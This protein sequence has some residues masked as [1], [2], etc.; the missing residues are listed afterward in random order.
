MTKE[1]P[2]KLL[3]AFYWPSQVA[4]P[5]LKGFPCKGKE[6]SFRIIGSFT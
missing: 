1:G 4:I 2:S 3:Y 6:V 5:I